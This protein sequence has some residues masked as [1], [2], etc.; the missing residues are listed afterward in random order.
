MM[1]MKKTGFGPEASTGDA[2]SIQPYTNTNIIK[3]A[4]K[5]KVF[6][7]YECT[8]YFVLTWKF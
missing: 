5:L 6:L 2:A 3:Y 4:C 8:D 7:K 1:R